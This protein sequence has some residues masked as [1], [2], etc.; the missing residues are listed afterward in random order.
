MNL[1]E[2]PFLPPP[3]PEDCPVVNAATAEAI[4]QTR[5]WAEGVLQG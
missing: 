5:F 3:P 1:S 4:A 2:E